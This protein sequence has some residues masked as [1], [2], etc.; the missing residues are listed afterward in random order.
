LIV[1]DEIAWDTESQ[2]ATKAGRFACE[3]LTSLGAALRLAPAL[4]LP[5]VTMSNVNVTAYS[6]SGN[7][8]WLNSG[9]RIETPVRF[10]TSGTY[11]FQVVAGGRAALGVLPQVG[12]TLDGVTR[13][14][15]FLSTTNMTAYTITLS[16]TAGTHQIGLAFLNDYWNPPEDRNAAF[17]PLTITPST[18]PRITSLRTDPLLHLATL[19]W[20][21]TAGKSC[22]VQ[23]ASNL[24][25]GFQAVA[26]VSNT[27]PVATW[28]DAGGT[29]GP[30][31]SGPASPQR[32]YRIRQTSP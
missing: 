22:E 27:G 9:G 19:Q 13:T 16:V 14:N 4:G 18:A 21:G 32:Y 17:G 5:S 8:A 23:L 1:L 11:T 6:V 28:Q 29:W 2:N 15:F 20:E 26:V 24:L 10:T 31:P 30:P 7:I 3:M 12:I 25:T